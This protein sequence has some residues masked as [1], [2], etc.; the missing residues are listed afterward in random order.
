[1][2]DSLF[3][4]Y[5]KVVL[6]NDFKKHFKRLDKKQKRFMVATYF[7]LFLSWVLSF[8]K[9]KYNAI[10]DIIYFIMI[11]I[12]I[13]LIIVGIVYIRRKNKLNTK[14]PFEEEKG[15]TPE[16]LRMKDV[17]NLLNSY[18]INISDAG[19]LNNLIERAKEEKPMYDIFVGFRKLFGNA[20]TS[21]IVPSITAVIAVYVDKSEWGN[22][23]I[24]LLLVFIVVWFGVSF[25]ATTNSYLMEF[26]I[27]DWHKLDYLIGDV[28]DVLDFPER[29][30]FLREQL[31][32][33]VEATETVS[34]IE[35][36]TNVKD[37][38]M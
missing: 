26:A 14:N 9:I 20:Y 29:A 7:G 34:D 17:I 8:I 27:T 25:V 28:R 6:V 2:F 5:K 36:Q 22:N 33:K 12:S 3:R 19:E 31:S 38:D 32:Q 37:Y 4:K 1:M 35:E 10:P 23:G 13:L 11:G 15:T 16:E 24:V 18:D 30:K 21:I